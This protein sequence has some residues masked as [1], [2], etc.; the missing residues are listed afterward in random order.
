MLGSALLYLGLVLAI[1]GVVLVLV[2]FA[3]PVHETRVAHA[4]THLDELMPRWQFS[5]H[6]SA[7][8]DASPE[9]VFEAI[10]EVRANEIALFRLLT[11]IRRGGRKQ[12]ENI[13][14]PGNDKPILDVATRSGFIPLA[15]DAP[16]ELVI[17]TA[18]IK[19]R[20]AEVTAQTFREPVPRGFAIAAMNFRVTPE[21]GGSLVETDTRVFASDARSLRNFK[22]YWRV[23]YPGS[24]LI[25]VM[26]LR[27][28]ARRAGRSS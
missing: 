8:V 11:W 15:D 21:G 26:W 25:R 27:A 3:L 13:L 19:P 14:N 10:R 9:R 22:R 24:S 20:G 7:H 4:Q 6:H 2:G 18:V 5:E 16:R 23:I 28:I 17:G 12:P 1:A